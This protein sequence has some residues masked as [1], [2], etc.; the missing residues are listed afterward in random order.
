MHYTILSALESNNVVQVTKSSLKLML[1]PCL[2]CNHNSKS[3][4]TG[5]TGQVNHKSNIFTVLPTQK[6]LEDVN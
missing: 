3:L 4:A 6:F 1:L 2:K 5:V